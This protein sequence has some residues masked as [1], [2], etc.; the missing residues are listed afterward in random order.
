M[1]MHI[2]CHTASNW[3]IPEAIVHCGLLIY[4]F[5]KETI[6]C[7]PWGDAMQIRENSDC[8]KMMEVGRKLLHFVDEQKGR[9]ET[10]GNS[11][12]QSLI[13]E[14][15]SCNPKSLK[16]LTRRMALDVVAATEEQQLHFHY[17]SAKQRTSDNATIRVTIVHGID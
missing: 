2:F 12:D 4:I 6:D 1:L 9:I 14:Q 17:F 7:N 3:N 5:N 16:Y 8:L 11:K 15:E 10:N 13:G